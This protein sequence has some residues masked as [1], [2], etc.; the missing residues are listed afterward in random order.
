MP[1][2]SELTT[3]TVMTERCEQ[4]E[5]A[6]KVAFILGAVAGKAFL[7]AQHIAGVLVATDGTQHRT[8]GWPRATVNEGEASCNGGKL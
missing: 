6:A 5:V 2:Q 8:A 3:V 4:A 1:A 7:E